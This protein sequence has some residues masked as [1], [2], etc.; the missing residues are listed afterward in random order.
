M[1]FVD[2]ENVSAIKNRKNK[3]MNV[4]LFIVDNN[5]GKL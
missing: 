2:G 3:N 5:E 1:K 4:L